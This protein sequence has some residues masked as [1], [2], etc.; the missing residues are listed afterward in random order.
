M[1]VIEILSRAAAK[2][3]RTAFLFL[4][5]LTLIWRLSDLVEEAITRTPKMSVGTWVITGVDAVVVQLVIV[6]ALGCIVFTSYSHMRQE[7]TPGSK[8]P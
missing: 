2:G 3:A 1:P 8:H 5:L 4:S 6:G 7:F